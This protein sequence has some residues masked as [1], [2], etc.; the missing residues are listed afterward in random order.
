MDFLNTVILIVMAGVLF[1]Q[2][3]IASNNGTTSLHGVPGNLCSSCDVA[4][5]KAA[6]QVLVQHG[7]SVNALDNSGA[8]PLHYA[9]MSGV[10][11][12]AN[13][14]LIQLGGMASHRD[15]NHSGFYA[16]YQGNGKVVESVGPKNHDHLTGRDVVFGNSVGR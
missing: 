2:T 5:R 16:A 8:I 11:D 9:L 13:V 14:E 15:D 3:T 1:C 4:E 6:A 7:V 12:D 10:A